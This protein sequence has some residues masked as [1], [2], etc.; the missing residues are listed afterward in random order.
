M[1]RA[2][3]PAVEHAALNDWLD[4]A[5][6]LVCNVAEGSREVISKLTCRLRL[7]LLGR[8]LGSIHVWED[9]R[10]RRPDTPC[11]CPHGIPCEA[12]DAPALAAR[13]RSRDGGNHRCTS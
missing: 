10:G 7:R 1:T 4:L 12:C 2:R 3:G 8:V 9:P 13:V 11:I 5:H 6:H